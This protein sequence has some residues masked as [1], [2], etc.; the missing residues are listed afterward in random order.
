[1]EVSTFELLYKR[2]APPPMMG[3]PGAAALTAVARRVV[4][5]YFLTISNLED[6]DFLYTLDFHI[7]LPTR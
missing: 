7:S 2:I 4:Q 1:M 3:T 5:G 6:E